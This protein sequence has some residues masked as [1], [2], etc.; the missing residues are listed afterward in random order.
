ME[1]YDDLIMVEGLK[2]S[3]ILANTEPWTSSLEPD[4][5]LDL[6]CATRP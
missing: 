5:P 2:K 6:D 3:I 1:L 4:Q